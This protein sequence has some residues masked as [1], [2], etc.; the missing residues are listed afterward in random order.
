MALGDFFRINMPYGIKINGDGEW[1][2]FNREYKPLGWNTDDFI[3]E[4]VYPVYTKYKGVTDKKL[5]SLAYGTE[6]VHFDE[7]GKINK[8]LFYN[9]GINPQSYPKY[10]SLYFDKIK[11]LSKFKII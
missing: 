1:F 5:V 4:E 9:D 8:I 2:A 10:W 6:G 7:N 3:K 11:A